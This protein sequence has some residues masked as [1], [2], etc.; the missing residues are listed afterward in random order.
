MAEVRT[1]IAGPTKG[2]YEWLEPDDAKVSS[3][4]PRGLGASDGPW[5]PDRLENNGLD[6]PHHLISPRGRN[7]PLPQEERNRE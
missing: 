5:P 4:V 3:P 6:F 2:P 1:A 7:V